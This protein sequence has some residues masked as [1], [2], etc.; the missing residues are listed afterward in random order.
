[1]KILKTVL[2]AGS[3]AALALQASVATAA[4]ANVVGTFVADVGKSRISTGMNRCGRD[5]SKAFGHVITLYDDGTFQEG[6]DLTGDDVADVQTSGLW[7]EPKEGYIAMIYSGDISQG[8]LGAGAW[9]ALFQ[10]FETSL[11][12]QCE[13]ASINIQYATVTVK[14]QWLKLNK[15]RTRG[16]VATEIHAYAQGGYVNP[17]KAKR[18]VHAKGAFELAK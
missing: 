5:K 18:S 8:S 13:D 6:L 2:L 3:L 16:E 10:S 4:D 1:M 9:G 12:E 17:G 14:K 11:R 7:K 15:K